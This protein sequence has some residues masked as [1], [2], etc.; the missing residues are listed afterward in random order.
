ML[1]TSDPLNM[2]SPSVTPDSAGSECFQFCW[3]DPGRG[4]CAVVSL[5]IDVVPHSLTLR[6]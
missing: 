6:T 3:V 2:A 1:D 4:L 5:F